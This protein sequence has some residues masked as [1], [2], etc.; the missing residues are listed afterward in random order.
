MLTQYISAALLQQR[1]T[2]AL[3]MGQLWKEYGLELHWDD[4][5]SMFTLPILLQ[6]FL[7]CRVSE[8]PDGRDYAS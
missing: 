7:H 2:F 4:H 6:F 5:S 1:N 3:A 8:F